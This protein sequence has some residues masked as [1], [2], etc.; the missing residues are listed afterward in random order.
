MPGPGAY[1]HTSQ[2]RSSSPRF[3]RGRLSLIEAIQVEARKTPGPAA[4]R[5]TPTFAEELAARREMKRMSTRA[6]EEA[7]AAVAW[8]ESAYTPCVVRGTGSARTGA[9]T[10]VCDCVRRWRAARISDSAIGQS[11]EY[12]GRYVYWPL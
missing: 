12:T 3:E 5:P 2:L 10:A 9:R 4:Y 8:K 1:Q 11:P 6:S 7:R